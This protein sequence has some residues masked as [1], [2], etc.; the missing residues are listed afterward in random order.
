MSERDLCVRVARVHLAEVKV[1]K[2]SEYKHQRLFAIT[3]LDWAGNARRR[4]FECINE[5]KI[6]ITGDMFT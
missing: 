3:L 5:Q 6:G 4:A 1:R 2:N